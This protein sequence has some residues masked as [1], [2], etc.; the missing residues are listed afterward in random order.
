MDDI[1]TPPA[2]TATES[3]PTS[4][5]TV[6]EATVEVINLRL[7]D[8][9]V[10]R[11]LAMFPNERRGEELI[12]AI[13]LGVHGLAATSMR[14]TVDDMKHEVQRI[15]ESA[16]A[17]A[18]SHLGRALETG[19][20][21]LLAQ[22]DPDVRSSLTART[23]RELEEL[24]AATLARLDP[25]RTDS[26]TGKLMASITDLL[27]PGGLLAQRL[28]AAFD[29]TEAESGF[30]R[31]LDTFERRFQEMR[32]LVVGDQQREAEAARGTAKGFD[33]EDEVESILRREARALSSCVV[34]RT[35]KVGG[36]LGSHVKVG[37]FVVV[38]PDG[39]TVAVEAKNTTRIG[40]T[41]STGI[42]TELDQAMDNRNATWSICVSHVDAYPGE[43][44]SFAVY[45][46]RILVVDEGDG[47]LTRVALR[48]IAAAAAATSPGD[49]PIDAAA[50]LERLARLRDLAQHF[51][52]SKKI[53]TTAQ[54]GLE[55]VR[56]D[57]D[58]LRS[59][60][61][62]L[63]DDI[64]RTLRPSVTTQHNAI[65]QRVA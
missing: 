59:Q 45:G 32:D 24:Y 57:L 8:E 21:E 3:N 28:E 38:L 15:I 14:A 39:T 25:D 58:S 35:G 7:T 9:A 61:L 33:F 16:A 23:V 11:Y 64:A 19:K 2:R 43:V 34:E 50:A 41:G 40:L 52:R 22:L 49:R 5:I 63:V 36:A 30:G 4:S 26:H 44:G 6:V 48:W 65:Q 13:T 27:G 54:S 53:L 10:A 12:R 42:L 18:D 20:S 31:L 55:S 29:S 56:E 62:D 51:S 46:N 1:T 37:D 47:T 17:A 60:L